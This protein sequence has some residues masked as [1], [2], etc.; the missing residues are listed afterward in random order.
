MAAY[1][2]ISSRF[3]S[4]REYHLSKEKETKKFLKKSGDEDRFLLTAGTFPFVHDPFNFMKE[5]DWFQGE[6]FLLLPAG[7]NK[8][9]FI[10]NCFKA[11]ANDGSGLSVFGILGSRVTS[12]FKRLNITQATKRQ[13][14]P[15]VTRSKEREEKWAPRAESLSKYNSAD[16]FKGAFVEPGGE[17]YSAA[18]LWKYPQCCFVNHDVIEAFGKDCTMRAGDLAM[19]ILE[20]Y[21]EKRSSNVEEK[22]KT[23]EDPEKDLKI[24]LFLWAVENDWMSK[25]ILHE[26]PDNESFD[27][28]AQ[29][30]R[31]KLDNNQETTAPKSPSH[32]SEQEDGPTSNNER[33]HSKNPPHNSPDRTALAKFSDYRGE[34]GKKRKWKK[35]R[36]SPDPSP[37]GSGESSSDDEG[38]V[39]PRA[40][41][42]R[43]RP[44]KS[45]ER[46]LA[47][48]KSK[49]SKTRSI[50]S[51]DSDSSPRRSVK[52]RDEPS[53]SSSSSSSSD[54]SS[55]SSS[56]S[57]S[58]SHR[59]SG[60]RRKKRQSRKSRKK[61]RGN[62]K[63]R[64]RSSSSSGD[65]RDLNRTMIRSLQAMTESQLK[66]DKKADKKKSMLSR[67][68]PEAGTLFTLLSARN[69]NDGNPKLPSLTKKILE[70][71]DSNRALGEVKSLSK[72]WT[73]RISEKGF[74][75][76]LAN[77]YQADDITDAPGG[78][79][80]FSFSPLDHVK[81]SDHK[82]NVHQV[83]SMFGSTELDEES[84]KYFSKKDFYLADS[85]AGLEEQV[86]T[87]I[88]C[89]EMLTRRDGI[90]SEGYVY[91]F[92]MIS[93]YK[94]EFL[95]L[96]R[97]DPLFPVKFAYLLDRVFQNFVQD[98]GDFH[99]KSDPIRRAKRSLKG[100]QVREI[101]AAMI[102]FKTGSLSHLFLPRTLQ[103]HPSKDAHPSTDGGAKGTGRDKKSR[104]EP[105][106][107][108]GAKGKKPSEEW[109]TTNP[110]PV[111]AWKIPE[112]NN[113]LGIFD[114][115]KEALKPNTEDWPK[116]A[117]HHPK[118][119]GRKTFLCLKYQTE[120]K[121]DVNCRKAH[122]IPEKIPEE[123]RKIMDERFLQIYG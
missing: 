60:N 50:D 69:W 94:R 62:K 90:A 28:L 79:S 56:S 92:E 89:L 6:A 108:E 106:G 5:I 48:S 68:S 54:P 65:D 44:S 103:G 55:D 39:S 115:T 110:S 9:S 2:T 13:M 63:R 113:F 102:G 12:P 99:S 118:A 49:S 97:M 51:E 80:V 87:C 42:A 35:E 96:F 95:A 74:L 1:M 31:S 75:L 59:R 72:R 81:S 16:S 10:H 45:K 15:Q 19:N 8:V 29:K 123:Q 111:A 14:P 119:K 26:V 23:K 105:K 37:S 30:V 93:K 78:F 61:R 71:R 66:R 3:P 67:L 27:I 20:A 40:S 17:G 114:F 47:R 53:P 91:G 7:G 83:R 18:E 32:D 122:V 73:G 33:I 58:D 34:S 43:E 46:S 11:D 100:Q 77:G 52:T 117:A 41:K 38:R 36:G 109:W 120:G 82:S 70:D 64:G 86:Y 88:K 4:W 112:G 22:D 24:L 25:V 101:D 104:G 57:D 85:L 116:F 84:I 76:F 107:E 98:L 121:C 21:L